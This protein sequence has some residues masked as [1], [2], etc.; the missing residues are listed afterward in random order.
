MLKVWV[1]FK[2]WSEFIIPA[3]IIVAT[4][5]ISTC[6]CLVRSISWNRKIRWL[7]AHNF[8]RYLV[9]VPSVGNGAF[10]GWRNEQ[11]GKKIDE[12]D[13]THLKFDAL[14]KKIKDDFMEMFSKLLC[15]HKFYK[16]GFREAYECGIR[17]SIRQY[18]C[19]KCAKEIWV[20]GRL[21]TIKD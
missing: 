2:V 14:V 19:A 8:E 20:D 7:R 9:G 6:L 17:Y 12:R 3:T 15:R 11:T 16:V 13:L 5:L 4:I 21:D 1:T 10:Y 18:R